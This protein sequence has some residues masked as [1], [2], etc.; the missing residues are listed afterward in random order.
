MDQVQFEENN[1]E[2]AAD[3]K[4]NLSAISRIVIRL[5][6][7]KDEKGVKVVLAV[8]TVACFLLTGF[9]LWKIYVPDNGGHRAPP[10]PAQY[11]N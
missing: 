4:S 3:K 10:L 2:C 7:A 11:P 9:L 5:H 8:I 6:L 1:M